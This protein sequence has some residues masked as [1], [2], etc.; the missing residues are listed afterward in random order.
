MKNLNYNQIKILITLE[1]IGE[2]DKNNIYILKFKNI[3]AI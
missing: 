3:Y 1:I 2:K